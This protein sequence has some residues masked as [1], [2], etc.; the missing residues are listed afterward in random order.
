MILGHV[1]CEKSWKAL[2]VYPFAML[3]ASHMSQYHNIPRDQIVWVHL[4]EWSPSLLSAP[5]F[6]IYVNRA[7]SPQRYLSHSHFE[8]FV[9]EQ[10]CPLQ[11][12]IGYDLFVVV[13]F[14]KKTK[15]PSQVSQ[16]WHTFQAFCSIQRYSITLC[17]VP[18]QQF[19]FPHM[20]CQVCVSH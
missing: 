15:F 16:P 19:L 3:L 2:D 7:I 5:T 13:A 9:D 8:W 6:G 18:L 20:T 17:L 4:V 10:I 14:F 1:R 11:T 12:F